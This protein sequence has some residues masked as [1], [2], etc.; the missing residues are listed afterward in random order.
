MRLINLFSVIGLIIASYFAYSQFYI[1][2]PGAS[3]YPVATGVVLS[4]IFVISYL[5]SLY[6]S[7][8]S[9][10]RI[11]A[12]CFVFAGVIITSLYSILVLLG[13]AD[14]PT[15]FGVPGAYIE[16]TVCFILMLFWNKQR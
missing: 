1:G 16:L 13:R 9:F 4:I 10:L 15:M 12:L 5:V 3:Y 7:S 8:S 2:T 11:T 6:N 14:Y